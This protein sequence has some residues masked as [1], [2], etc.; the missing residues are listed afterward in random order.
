MTNARALSPPDADQFPQLPAARRLR[1]ATPGRSCCRTE[2]RRQN[3]SDRGD[4][5]SRARTR[6]APR[7]ARR[8]RVP[9]RRRLLG[10]GRRGRGRARARDARHRHRARAPTRRQRSR[11]CRIDRE[12]VASAAAFADHLRVVWLTPAMDSLFAGAPSER[13]RF[14]DR[15]A[16][17]VDAEHGSRVNALERAL[18]SRNRLLEEPQPRP[19]L[20]RRG[21]ARD[22]G[23][24][25]R[26]RGPAGRNGPPARRR[27]LDSRR[28]FRLSAGRDC[29]R[30]LD[31]A[32]VPGAS[33][34]R[35][36]GAL[37]RRAARQ[38]RPR[39]RRRPHA[40][41]PASDRSW[42]SSMCARISP[43]PPPRPAS[44]RR[45]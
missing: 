12:P 30:R 17:A 41:R 20:A 8:S 26:G 42:L 5:V 9:G 25:G 40:R 39:R 45:C 33:G 14:L 1:P 10:G 28:E 37:P 19:A 34:G 4:F 38:S 2:R 31:G 29:P 3:Q 23:A 15:L 35:R 7:D 21:G 13:R 6:A 43:P 44:R 24:C 27:V 22:G 11:K 32:A 18:R 36:R 16:L